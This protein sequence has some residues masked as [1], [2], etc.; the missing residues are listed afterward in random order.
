VHGIVPADTPPP[1][2]DVALVPYRRVAALVRPAEAAP[3][4]AL[5]S[6]AAG[7]RGRSRRDL[8][9]AHVTLLDNTAATT[10]VIPLRLG[11]ALDSPEAVARE[12]LAPHHDTFLAAL[13][14]LAGRAQFT[15]RARYVQDAIVREVLHHDPGARVLHQRVQGASGGGEDHGARVV[16]GEAVAR[17]ILARR[18]AD[19]ATLA[20][21][22]RPYAT[23]A[24]VQAPT[25][26]ESYR[27]ADAAF[28]VDLRRQAVF[29]EVLERL[30]SRWRKR[31][32][33]RLLGPMAAYHFADHLIN[34]HLDGP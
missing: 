23:L 30:A 9:M 20:E 26:V 16:L 28:V 21:T 5:D 2:D 27:I 4:A 32:T 15:V 13:G 31:A 17:G 33:L 7:R 19:A 12:L 6:A 18:E 24:A 14:A 8:I 11:T 29:E 1:G 10:P 25:S 3:A 34:A 22:L